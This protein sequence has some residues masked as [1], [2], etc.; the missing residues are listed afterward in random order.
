MRTFLCLVLIFV[1]PSLTLAQEKTREQKV[2]EDRQKV[3]A[4]GFWIYNDLPQAFEQARQTGKP[5]LVVLRCIPCEE[6]VKLDDELMDQ[7]PVIRPLMEQFVCARQ[8]S[9]N[10]L[11]LSLFQFDTDQSFAVF[12]LNADGTIYGRFGTRSHRTEWYGDVSIEGLAKALQ[13]ALELHADYPASRPLVAGKRGAPLEVASPEQYPTLRDRY[14]DTL[15]VRGDVVK[16][17]IHCHQI[18]DAQREWYRTKGEPIPAKVLFPHPHPKVL[19]LTLDPHEMARV[20]A[21]EPDSAAAEAGLRAGDDIE[22]LDS[23]TLLSIADF[24]WALHNVDPAG[25]E[26]PLVVRRGDRQ[27]E[28][29]LPLE[30]GWRETGDLSWRVSSWGLRRMATG[31]LLLEPLPEEERSQLN[32]ADEAMALRVKHV[33]QYGPHAT[34]KKAGFQQGDIL[35][36]F[37]GRSDLMTD[38]ALLVHGV[39]HR[40]P[41]ERVDVT[42]LRNGTRRTLQLPMQQ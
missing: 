28:L 20:T 3:E 23:Q 21:V 33:G 31:G 14:T 12:T 19:G 25:A 29:T 32:L 38:T 41:G 6:C 40:E 24:Q 8:V 34:A 5:I 42:V 18:G 30:G 35:V 2:R 10:G 7:D 9:T 1:T 26:V 37:D 17:C 27:L 15:N 39:T 13:K 16:S 4:D 11:D 36:E 22:Q